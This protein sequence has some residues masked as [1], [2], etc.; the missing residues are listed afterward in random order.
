MK[1][2][3]CRGLECPLP[4]VK[5]KE[6]LKKEESIRVLVDNSVAVENLTKFANV[7][8]F[9]SRNGNEGKDYFVEI[10]KNGKIDETV[11]EITPCTTGKMVVV[12]SSDKMGSN[13]DLGKILMKAFV[14]ALTKQDVLPDTL[15]FYNE[16]VKLTTEEGDILKDIQALETQGVEVVSCGT[17]LEFFGL[18]EE[19]KVGSITN[20]YDIVERQEQAAKIIKP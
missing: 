10:S 2:L 7:K 9:E 5:T 13:P 16:G 6:E 11:V 8:G 12:F 3:D 4:V 18:K 15:I 19:L 20:M 17:C 1:V 14:F